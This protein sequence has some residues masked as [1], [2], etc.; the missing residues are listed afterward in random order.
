[1]TTV[2]LMAF[3]PINQTWREFFTREGARLLLFARQQT[4]TEADAQDVLQEAFLKVWKSRDRRGAINRAQLF[5][6]IRRV[7]IDHGR[8]TDR[9]QA[10]ESTGGEPAVGEAPLSGRWFDRPLEAI[11]RRQVLMRALDGLP[12][13]QQEVLLLKIWGELT[14]EAIAETLGIPPNTAASRYRYGLQALKRNLN[15]ASLGEAL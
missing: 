10:R 6:E 7:A 15:P 1:M 9:R 13:E 4:R 5:A 11:E 3:S 2:L 8:K 12:K 14:F